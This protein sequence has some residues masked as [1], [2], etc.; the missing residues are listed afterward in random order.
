MQEIHRMAKQQNHISRLVI[1][2]M[3][4]TRH[5]P[6][7]TKEAYLEARGVVTSAPTAAALLRMRLANLMIHLGESGKHRI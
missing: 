2:P 5:T 7:N 6:L 3:A 4:N 1:R